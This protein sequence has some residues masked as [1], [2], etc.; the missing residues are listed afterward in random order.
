ME[1]I[2]SEEPTIRDNLVFTLLGRGLSEGAL[3]QEQFAYV[4]TQSMAKDLIRYRLDTKLPATL[5]RSFTALLNGFIVQV[6]GSE[7]SPYHHL[8]MPEV[9]DYFWLSASQY[10]YQ[11]TDRT[12]YSPQYGWVHAF[13]HAGDYLSKVVGHDLF[14]Q[15]FMPDVLDSLTFV[16][17]SSRQ[18]FT[19]GKGRRL[20]QALVTGLIQE[21]LTQEQLAQWIQ[22]HYFALEELSDFYQL[23][24]F[25]DMLAYVYFHTL[26]TLVLTDDL[27]TALL[28]YLKKY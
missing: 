16:I 25:E 17:T 11:E 5:T 18:P 6:D 2:G 26:D 14:N 9:R 24:L 13:A 4:S 10:L 28:G 3:T 1:Q 19:D 23:A 8:L 7:Q 27:Q 21:K 20:A 22:S 15:S 12:G